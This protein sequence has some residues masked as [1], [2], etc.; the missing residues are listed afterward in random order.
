MRD[1][2]PAFIYKS[3][4]QQSVEARHGASVEVLLRRLYVEQGLTQDQVAATL[5]VERKA[6]VRWM[7]AFAIPARDR[8]KVAA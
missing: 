2:R 6:V 4:T 5:G 8:R 7:A 1:A 3:R